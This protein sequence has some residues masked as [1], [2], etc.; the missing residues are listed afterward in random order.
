MLRMLRG[1]HKATPKAIPKHD[2]HRQIGHKL[3]PAFHLRL[4][5]TS[6]S[7]SSPAGNDAGVDNLFKGKP[8][9]TQVHPKV[10]FSLKRDPRAEAA[11]AKRYANYEARLTPANIRKVAGRGLMLIVYFTTVGY[12]IFQV[13]TYFYVVNLFPVADD[14]KGIKARNVA[15]LATYYDIFEHQPEK[16]LPFYKRALQQFLNNGADPNSLAVMNFELNIERCKYELGQLSGIEEKLTKMLTALEELRDGPQETYAD[17]KVAHH[18]EWLSTDM[19][20]FKLADILGPTY[21]D[22]GKI[23]QAIDIYAIGLRAVKALKLTVSE[24][25]D[26][27]DIIDYTTYDHMN[28]KEASMSFKLGKAFYAKQDYQTA[29]TLFRATINYC[30]QHKTHINTAPRLLPEWRAFVDGWICL[31]SAAMEYLARMDIDRGN[32]GD[33]LPWIVAGRKL[34]TAD[35]NYQNKQC[36]RCESGFMTQL[37]RIAEHQGD[38]QRALVRYREAYDYLYLN[39]MHKFEDKLEEKAA[40]V[41]RIKALRAKIAN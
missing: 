27:E 9:F 10:V 28:L 7:G 6:S 18:S 8:R 37:G 33:A 2:W 36:I 35:E 14:L 26:T 39:F 17:D 5:S 4:N 41:D 24:S 22:Q 16:A 21:Y 13:V 34:A 23:D 25:F 3:L 1:F 20:I 19:L 11:A 32:H 29:E 38:Y 40:D 30:R 15:Y 12:I 31:D